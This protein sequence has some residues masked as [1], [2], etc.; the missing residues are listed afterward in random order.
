MIAAVAC[1]MVSVLAAAA[2]RYPP[3]AAKLAWISLLYVPTF[4][5]PV[6][7]Y[8]TEQA[9]VASSVQLEG[10]KD[11]VAFPAVEKLTT[12]PVTG[13]TVPLSFA[14]TVRAAVDP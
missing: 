8:W 10:L 12:P 7:M 5:V 2:G 13:P 9:P 11:P 4:N 6:G 14:V 3:T 1:V